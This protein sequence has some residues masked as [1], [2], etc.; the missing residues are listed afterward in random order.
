MGDT[1]LN[2]SDIKITNANTGQE[3]TIGGPLKFNVDNK[4]LFDFGKFV[5]S[6]EN[7]MKIGDI[8]LTG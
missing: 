7:Y 4:N 1:N 8:S 2:L 3:T 6:S 5:Y